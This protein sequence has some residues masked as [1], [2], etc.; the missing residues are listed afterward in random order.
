MRTLVII[1]S[2]GHGRELVGVVDALN[3][4]DASGGWKLLGFIDDG[5]P[6]PAMLHRLG[7]THLGGT[8]ALSQFAEAHFVVGIGDGCVRRRI[9]RIATDAGLHAATLIHPSA[10][11]G[12]DVRVEP[13]V[14]V[15]AHV[16][17]TTNVALGRHVHINRHAAVGHDTV[18]G[19]HATV[20]PS[21]TVSGNVSVAAGV[22]IGAN[23]TV[24]PGHRVGEHSIIGAGAVV[25]RD[26]PAGVTAVGVP[27][28]TR[29]GGS[30]ARTRCRAET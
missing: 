10:T 13:G 28:R 16:S 18:F 3:A 7:L 23:A 4:S 1:G 26:V 9:D 27:A 12:R 2:G 14:V 19:D 24:I 8:R 17:V 5:T 6:D 25:V 21:A 22:T 29:E 15:C 20:H 11:I 30:P